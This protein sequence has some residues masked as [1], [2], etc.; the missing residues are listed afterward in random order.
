M[1]ASLPIVANRDWMCR[2]SSDE[3]S[4]LKDFGGRP[5][6]VHVSVAGVVPQEVQRIEERLRSD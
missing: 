5:D 6:A 2:R 1:P 3:A 4:R